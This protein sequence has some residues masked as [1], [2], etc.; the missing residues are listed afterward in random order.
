V[1]ILERIL[2]IAYLLTGRVTTASSWGVRC[3]AAGTGVILFVPLY[4]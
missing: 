2:P 3:G 4:R 1:R